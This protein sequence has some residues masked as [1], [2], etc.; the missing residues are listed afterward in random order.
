VSQP[1]VEEAAEE[2]DGADGQER[3]RP[4]RGAQCRQV[5]EEEL[6]DAESE[7]RE[8]TE[9]KRT[10]TAAQ[11]GVEQREPEQ[12]PERADAGVAALEVRVH[13][14]SRRDPLGELE[15][16]EGETVDGEDSRE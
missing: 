16:P 2:Q 12:A 4:C 3:D 13:V 9:A 1:L 6:P 8:A 5:V 14:A 7:E 11:A 10:L 15:D